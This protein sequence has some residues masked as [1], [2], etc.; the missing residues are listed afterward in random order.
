M[1]PKGNIHYPSII[2]NI[3]EL[4]NQVYNLGWGENHAGN[5]SCILDE[6]DIFNS[7]NIKDNAEREKVPLKFKGSFIANKY[8]LVTAAGFFFRNVIKDTKQHLG[9]IHVNGEGNSYKKFWTLNS[10]CV[11]TF[12]E[13][14][15]LLPWMVCGNEKIGIET[16]YKMLEFRIV[17]WPF[18]GALTAGNSIDEALGLVETIEKTSKIFVLLKGGIKHFI[19]DEQIIDLAKAFNLTI[20]KD[21]LT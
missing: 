14:F 5:I 19:T 21:V 8:L 20:K 12:P 18:H 4:C 13:G 7:Y 15:G 6:N 11:L 9:I 16:A 1:R 3:V 2:S 17:I 10:E